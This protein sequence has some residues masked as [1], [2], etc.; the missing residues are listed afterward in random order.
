MLQQSQSN[1]ADFTTGKR[2]RNQQ[3]GMICE[4]TMLPV[5]I[6]DCQEGYTTQSG[7][8]TLRYS[9]QHLDSN[10]EFN[11]TV[12]EK[13]APDYIDQKILD[14]VLPPEMLDYGLEDLIDRGLFIKVEFNEKN[15]FTHIN[16]KKVAALDET[17]QK[18]LDNLLIEE[19]KERQSQVETIKDIEDEME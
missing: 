2:N 6:T 18:V 16:V 3:K 8:H 4:G 7:T 5:R 9:F 14:V 11:S 15:G 1:R 13:S 12:F 17:Y 19:E 10:E